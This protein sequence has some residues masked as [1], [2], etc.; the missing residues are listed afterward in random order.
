MR[1]AVEALNQ[2]S[3][4]MAGANGYNH[5]GPGA[6]LVAHDVSRH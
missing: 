1:L 6:A 3:A 4:D 2:E 5:H